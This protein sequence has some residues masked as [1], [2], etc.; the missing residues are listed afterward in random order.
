MRTQLLD[1]QV[2][3]VDSSAQ[4]SMAYVRQF[5][6]NHPDEDPGTVA[7]DGQLA[8]AAFTTRLLQ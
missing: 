2:N 5:I 6:A 1:L 7:A 3:F 4:G 8:V